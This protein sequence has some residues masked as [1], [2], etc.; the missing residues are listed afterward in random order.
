MASFLALDLSTGA[1][2]LAAPKS[3]P[4]RIL[5]KPVAG[6]DEEELH[7]L[8]R[9]HGAVQT[10]KMGAINVRILKVPEPA[11]AK[12][13]EALQHHP[14]IQFA[15]SDQIVAPQ[16][17]PSDP[18]FDSQWHLAAV[19]APQAWDITT[20]DGGVIIAVLDTGVDASHPDLA[21][22]LVPGWNIYEDNSDTSDVYGHGTEVAGTA[23]AA[24]DNTIGVASV[25]FNCRVMP[26]RVSQED[27]MASYSA[28][29]AGL[30]YAAD[31]GARVANISYMVTDSS[32]VTSA[33]QYFES[34]GGVTVVAAG[35]EGAFDSSADNP[36]V[37]TVSATG[38][39]DVLTSWSCTGNN[40]D[41]AAPGRGIWNTTR[42]G[43]YGAGSGTSFSAP[44]VAAAAALVISANP[45]LS[46]TQVQDI[47]KQSA[48][49]LGTP[50][51]DAGYGWGRVNAYRAVV[52]A[53]NTPPADMP[54]PENP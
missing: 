40:I 13:L 52:A 19:Q 10:D 5:L 54:P 9:R 12:V 8:F 43:G 28:I 51:W 1:D 4:G 22:N 6:V 48:D 27:G 32:T 46:G 39:D 7:G 25:A 3:V 29:A 45:S 47:L 42:G 30:T 31:H 18:W 35:N 26:V 41:L 37:L 44:I 38:P 16:L 24:G 50:G 15:E 17:V 33:A 20:G 49:D 36:Y 34:K 14:H 11:R 2:L 23:G 53:M 21:P